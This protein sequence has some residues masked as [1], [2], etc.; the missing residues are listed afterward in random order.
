MS[1][2]SQSFRLLPNLV[3]SSSL[4]DELPRAAPLPHQM[5]ATLAVFVALVAVV[6]ATD[7]TIQSCGT[8]TCASGCHNQTV[9]SGTCLKVQGAKS[10]TYLTISDY[11]GNQCAKAALFSDSKCTNEVDAMNAV[12]NSCQDGFTF[13]C[14]AIDGGVFWVNNC[15]DPLCNMCTG[16][17]IVYH[18]HC[19][20]VGPGGYGLFYG[21]APC[22]AV[23]VQFY[24]TS[25][26]SGPAQYTQQYGIGK[27]VKGNTFFANFNSSAAAVASAP[28]V[29]V[30][31]PP[32]LLPLPLR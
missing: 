15:S 30:K 5:R 22:E 32:S 1:L 4:V 26:C 3:R 6:S 20:Q 9:S 14:G 2:F 23:N 28:A 10:P 16:V 27:C 13:S 18:N 31:L 17:N 11:P 8:G 24:N 21:S 25:T 19:K 7:V 29:E 12:C